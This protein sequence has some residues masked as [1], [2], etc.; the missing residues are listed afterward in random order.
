MLSVNDGIVSTAIL[1]QADTEAADLER[2][3]GDLAADETAETTELA[4]IY[5]KRGLAVPL[6]RQVAEQLAR[7]L[8]RSWWPASAERAYCAERSGSCSGERSRWR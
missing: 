8:R 7:L 3:R 1:P 6:A 5:E 2:E 4:A